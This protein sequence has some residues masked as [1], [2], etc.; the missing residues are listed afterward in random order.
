MSDIDL[1]S[2]A[3]QVDQMCLAMKTFQKSLDG[4]FAEIAVIAAKVCELDT[5]MVLLKLPEAAHA[6][7]E[8]GSD[9]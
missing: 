2:L 9:C 6:A 5:D 3:A 7:A 4:L 8:G 1:P